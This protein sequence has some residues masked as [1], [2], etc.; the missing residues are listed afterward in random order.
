MRRAFTLIEMLIAVALGTVI[1]YTV[2]AAFRMCSQ[3]VTVANRIALE[4][5][6]FRY[7]MLDAL[8]DLD[9]WHSYDSLTDPSKRPLRSDNYYPATSPNSNPF[10]E[11]W[12]DP[13]FRQDLPRS[14]WRGACLWHTDNRYG[15]YSWFSY[16]GHPDPKNSW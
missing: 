12:F 11:M 10:R 13:D 6:L 14:W 7:A 4:N 16:D 9:F 1:C 2:F 15:D 3:T 5:S 8:E